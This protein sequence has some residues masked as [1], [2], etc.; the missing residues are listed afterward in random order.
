MC[1]CVWCT[2]PCHPSTWMWWQEGQEFSLYLATYWGW[3]QPRFQWTQSQNIKRAAVET[4]QWSGCLPPR[5]RIYTVGG[6]NPV[7]QVFLWLLYRA[8]YICHPFPL[9]THCASNKRLDKIILI[10]PCF[11]KVKLHIGTVRQT[12]TFLNQCSKIRIKMRITRMKILMKRLKIS[13]YFVPV[14]LSKVWVILNGFICKM[15]RRY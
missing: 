10:F 3:G 4:V 8:W 14:I 11:L 15:W 12:Q 2:H 1:C 13:L 9:N 7:L 6:E 5:L